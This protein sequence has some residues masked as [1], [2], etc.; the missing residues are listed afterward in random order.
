MDDQGMEFLLHHLVSAF[1]ISE[2]VPKDRHRDAFDG[3]KQQF[4]CNRRILYP[5]FAAGLLSKHPA[6]F[7][8]VD[9]AVNFPPHF[10]RQS[11]ERE[12]LRLHGER[13][14]NGFLE[15]DTRVLFVQDLGDKLLDL[16]LAHA[17]NGFQQAGFVLEM[18]EDQAFGNLGFLSD[19]GS[20]D[21][22]V[23]LLG[24]RA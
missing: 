18:T 4:G 9:L 12:A 19:P 17:K 20:G 16:G 11:P 15:S 14:R 10:E 8:V 23:T 2:F 1:R 22:V 13:H 6:G 7:C 24:N 21:R 3:I 5:E